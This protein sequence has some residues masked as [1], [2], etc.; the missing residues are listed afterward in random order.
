MNGLIPNI[1]ECVGGKRSLPGCLAHRKGDSCSTGVEKDCALV[2]S[3]NTVRPREEVVRRRVL[4]SVHRNRLAG[5]DLGFQNADM[6]V[7]HQKLVMIRCGDQRV[8]F[9]WPF[10][11]H[12]RYFSG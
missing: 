4:V 9:R 3:P 7:L 2:V 11:R 6:L 1:F 12:G 8:E 5:T 10:G